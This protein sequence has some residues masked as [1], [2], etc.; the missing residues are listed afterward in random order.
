MENGIK[1]ISQIRRFYA[2]GFPSDGPLNYE[3]SSYCQLWDAALNF[4]EELPSFYEGKTYIPDDNFEQ[5]LI[6]LGY[7]D[8]LDDYVITENISSISLLDL[9]NREISNMTGLEDFISITNLILHNNLLS[10]IDVSRNL[11]LESLT[12]SRNSLTSLDVSENIFL[13]ELYISINNIESLDLSNNN[14][15]IKLSASQNLLTSLNLSGN[16]QLSSLNLSGDFSNGGSNSSNRNRIPSIDLSNNDNLKYLNLSL[17]G[18]E[19]TI[20]TSNLDDLIGLVVSDN[21]NLISLDLSNNRELQWINAG[22]NGR[23]EGL[24]LTNQSRLGYLSLRAVGPYFNE[25]DVSNN[26]NLIVFD[27]TQ[28][29]DTTIPKCIKVSQFQMDNQINNNSLNGVTSG[30]RVYYDEGSSQVFNSINW[31]KDI[32][33]SYELECD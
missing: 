33:N 6:D 11:L 16:P 22:F 10:S 9:R 7:D 19:G 25:L 1:V 32:D 20:D 27:T 3:N 15:L 21:P 12:L 23:L 18:I 30:F 17:V 2:P 31:S 8:T 4:T 14:S 24:D 26:N 5:A 28:M 29:G 13:E